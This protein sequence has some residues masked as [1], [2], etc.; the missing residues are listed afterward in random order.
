MSAQEYAAVVGIEPES[1]RARF[2]AELGYISA[3]VGANAAIFDDDDRILLVHRADD[4]TWGLVAGWV[5]TGEDPHETVV[6]EIAEEIGV[7]GRVE[8]LV[9][10]FGRAGHSG[11]GPHGAVSVLF[12]CSVQSRNFRAQPHEVLDIGWHRIEDVPAWHKDHETYAYAAREAW[13]RF[14]AGL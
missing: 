2:D 12:L 14:R 6:R 1:V 8:R 10:V 11:L 3:K 5:D 4:E 7:P 9:N 13:W